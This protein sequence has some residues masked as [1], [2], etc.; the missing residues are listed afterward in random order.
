MVEKK[1]GEKNLI[2]KKKK[3]RQHVALE[4][5]VQ[6]FKLHTKGMHDAT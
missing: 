3:E 4:L 1:E 2:K 6:W 5:K